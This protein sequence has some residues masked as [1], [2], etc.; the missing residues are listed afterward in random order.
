[1]FV[2]SARPLTVC[3]VPALS[4]ERLADCQFHE[5]ETAARG[6]GSAAQTS[7][8]PE[9]LPIPVPPT[10]ADFGRKKFSDS[11]SV[12]IKTNP[13]GLRHNANILFLLKFLNHQITTPADPLMNFFRGDQTG[14]QSRPNRD[15]RRNIFATPRT[16]VFLRT[17]V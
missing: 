10:T 4:I 8:E 15:W 14:P 11:I 16:E 13:E 5:E 9:K 3:R 1:V 7:L 12:E 6:V 2:S 17:K